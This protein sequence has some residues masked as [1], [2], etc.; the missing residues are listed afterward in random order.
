[1]S[2]NKNT[3]RSEKIKTL[4][5]SLVI[6]VVVW[7]AII[8]ILDPS[9][10][11]T[12][13]NIKVEYAGEE[14]LAKSNLV[15]A[16]K[17]EVPKLA[18]TMTG[19]RSDLMRFM[20]NGFVEIDVSSI[21]AAGTYNLD[22]TVRYPGES[23]TV[24]SKKFS[25]VEIR[26]ETLESKELPVKI[27]Q[28]GYNPGILVKSETFNKTFVFKGTKAL[29]SQASTVEIEVDVSRIA[30]SRN[31]SLPYIIRDSNGNKLET[32][33][34]F[35]ANIPE[36]IISNTVYMKK[37]LKI[38]PVLSEELAKKYTLNV[39]K[40]VLSPESV[41]VG[42]LPDNKDEFIVANIDNISTGT[43]EYSLV[44]TNGMYLP[45]SIKKVKIKTDTTVKYTESNTASPTP[46]P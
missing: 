40:C 42:V 10:S 39:D 46:Q 11:S 8:L 44:E 43:T 19:S 29:V 9:I 12:F 22:G 38:K 4:L 36:I 5:V 20:K 3:T 15:V 27:K 35:F 17:E 31:L 14:K 26:V 30:E 34:V 21:T 7:V 33:D 1:M 45:D 6:A 23:L 13:S 28:T 16:N 37:S 41:E 24:K 25:T 18:A 2:S 32:G